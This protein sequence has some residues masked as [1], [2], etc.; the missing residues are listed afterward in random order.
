MAKNANI[1]LEIKALRRQ[2]VSLE[3]RCQE[4]ED[5]ITKVLMAIEPFVEV[6]TKAQQLELEQKLESI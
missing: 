1:Y 2:I 6:L 5:K 3:K 4:R